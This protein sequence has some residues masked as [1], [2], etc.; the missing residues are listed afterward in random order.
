MIIPSWLPEARQVE[1]LGAYDGLS[2]DNIPVRPGEVTAIIYPEDPKSQ[3]KHFIE[4][5]VEVLH[6]ENRTATPVRYRCMLANRLAGLADH[7]TYTLRPR[8]K[9]E[10]GDP[11]QGSLVLVQCP[12]GERSLSYIVGGLRD[13]GKDDDL[14]TKELG[15]HYDWEFN[16]IAV[17][18]DKTGAWILER[19]GPTQA[20]GTVKDDDAK[21][22]GATITVAADGSITVVSPDMKQSVN[23]DHANHV[24][25]VTGDA[26][27]VTDADRIEHGVDADQPHLCGNDWSDLMKDILTEIAKIQVVCA[28]GQTSIPINTPQLLAFIPKLEKVKSGLAF[29]KKTR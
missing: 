13:Q 16:G 8:S 9:A 7:E 28:V 27:V 11:V 5:D 12:N 1:Q 22:A 10:N 19:R 2:F 6:R 23:I 4:Y 14:G 18:V 17:G 3:T 26:K 21:T 20:D 25:V 29:L 24:V 15:H